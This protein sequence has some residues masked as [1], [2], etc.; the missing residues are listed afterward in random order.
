M[1]ASCWASSTALALKSSASARLRSVTSCATP[2]MRTARP[3]SSHSKVTLV[4]K[5]RTAPPSSTTRNSSVR[6]AGFTRAAPSR[7]RLTR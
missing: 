3:A 6:G 5:W 1:P 4:L 7:A 2:I